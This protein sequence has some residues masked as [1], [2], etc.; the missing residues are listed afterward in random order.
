MADSPAD[1]TCLILERYRG[2]DA[3]ALNQ[4]FARYYD[5]MLAVV[6]LRMGPALR[7]KFESMDVAQEAF[8]AGMK[9]LG[10]FRPRGEGDFFHWLCKVAENRIRDQVDHVGAQKRNVARE[11][12][13]EAG[14][15]GADSL[16]GP[17]KDLA[18]FTSPA[19]LA[20]RAEDIKRL[21]AAI[22]ALPGPQREALLLVRYEGLTFQEAGDMLGRTADATRMLVARAMVGLGKALGVVG[23]AT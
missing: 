18:T 16:Y 7:G 12:P 3:G 8:I 22:D 4:L 20:G 14:R 15:P 23:G 13:L 21:E 9:G 1:A 5:R 17:I 2:G 11:T 19:S 6:R 10:D